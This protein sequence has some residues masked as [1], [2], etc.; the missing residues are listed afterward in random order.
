MDETAQS[1]KQVASGASRCC[2]HCTHFQ[3]APAFI[4]AAFP[5]I[6]AMCSGSASVRDH[7]GLCARHGRY[8][9]FRDTCRDFSGVDLPTRR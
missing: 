8:L 1:V 5:G 9:S 7:D 2:G 4:E 6:A 3:N